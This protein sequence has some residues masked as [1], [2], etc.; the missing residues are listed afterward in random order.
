MAVVA[1]VAEG[2]VVSPRPSSNS[3][4]GAVPPPRSDV[5]GVVPGESV[6]AGSLG[7]AGSQEAPRL[8]A[9]SGPF[10]PGPRHPSVLP[11]AFRSLLP[12]RQEWRLAGPPPRAA[13]RPGLQARQR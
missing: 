11:T 4:L 1:A 13:A 8:R 3:G 6:A 5:T 10:L 7:P 12:V 2:A 9:P